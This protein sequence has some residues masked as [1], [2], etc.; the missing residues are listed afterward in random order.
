MKTKTLRAYSDCNEQFPFDDRNLN[1]RA[2]TP[3]SLAEAAEILG[4]AIPGGYNEFSAKLILK[5][6]KVAPNCQ[7]YMAREGSVCLYLQGEPEDLKKIRK[8]KCLHVDECDF[9]PDGTLRLWWD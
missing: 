7:V 3:V 6:Q 2:E 9:E 5:I 8:M 4:E 1:F